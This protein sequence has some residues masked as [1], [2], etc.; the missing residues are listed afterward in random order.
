M[1]GSVS[2]FL[3]RHCPCPVLIVKMDPS[4]IEARK[5]MNDKKQASFN[6]IL[7]KR[8]FFF[9]HIMC[10]VTKYDKL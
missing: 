5:E 7:G 1:L 3:T 2:N 6:N 10:I 8:S 4:E 9:L